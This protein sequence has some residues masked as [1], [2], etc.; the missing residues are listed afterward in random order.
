MKIGDLVKWDFRSRTD[1]NEKRVGLIVGKDFLYEGYD[2]W[3]VLWSDGECYQ[4]D[5]RFIEV[6]Q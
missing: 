2:S 5:P 4:V 3:M 6:V 1:E